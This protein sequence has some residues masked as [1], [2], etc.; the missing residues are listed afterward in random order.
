MIFSQREIHGYDDDEMVPWK[1]YYRHR[2]VY[3]D[4]DVG[5]LDDDGFDDVDDVEDDVVDHG[6]DD[7]EMVASKIYCS[8]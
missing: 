5:Y 3:D 1:I 4:D 6:Y 7:D 2:E 8:H